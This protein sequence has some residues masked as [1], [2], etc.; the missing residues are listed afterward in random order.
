METV[1]LQIIRNTLYPLGLFHT[2]LLRK[3]KLIKKFF[4]IKKSYVFIQ[5][6]YKRRQ[7]EEKCKENEIFQ[8][9]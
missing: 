3:N 9:Y 8:Y 6:H 2:A 4:W 7:A 5:T 1:Y